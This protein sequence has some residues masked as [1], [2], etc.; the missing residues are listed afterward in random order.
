MTRIRLPFLSACLIVSFLLVA[1]PSGRARAQAV[2]SASRVTELSLFGAFQNLHPDWG[3]TSDNGLVAGALITHFMRGPILPSFEIR[4][5]MSRNG[6]AAGMKTILYGGRANFRFPL[7]ARFHPYANFLVGTGEIDFAHPTMTIRGPYGHD[8]STV[9]NYGGGGEFAVHRNAS[10]I[11][12]FQQQHWNL[13]GQEIGH[14]I[15]TPY[16]VN[17]GLR[18]RIPFRAHNHR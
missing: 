7:V 8:D 11:A 2:E 4:G 12:E 1:L 16:S 5:S 6:E 18:Y 14:V 3:H 13:G 17:L 10:L 15:L 9:Y